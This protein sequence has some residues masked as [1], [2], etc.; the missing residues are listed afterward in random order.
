MNAFFGAYGGGGSI[1]RLRIR[2]H[3]LR[4]FTFTSTQR[5]YHCAP[6]FMRLLST[7]L[8]MNRV[9]NA[10]SLSVIHFTPIPDRVNMACRC[11]PSGL[12]LMFID[13]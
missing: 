7:N 13:P 11:L 1:T 4:E 8:S 2:T 3:F 10:Y 6:L 5:H 12:P 9:R